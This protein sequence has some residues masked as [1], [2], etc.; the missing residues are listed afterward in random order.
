[1]TSE[2]VFFS[3]IIES[4]DSMRKAQRV[5][6]DGVNIVKDTRTESNQSNKKGKPEYAVAYYKDDAIVW[7]RGTKLYS[8]SDI[9]IDLTFAED[10]FLT[11]HCHGGFLASTRR[12]LEEIKPY[13]IGKEKIT[14]IGH[15]LGGACAAIAAMILHYEEHITNVRALT[16]AC[17]GIVTPDV[18]KLGVPIITAIARKQDPIPC[19]FDL[20]KGVYKTINLCKNDNLIPACTVPGRLLV[21]EKNTLRKTVVLRKYQEGDLVLHSIHWS[22]FVAHSRKAYMREIETVCGYN[23]DKRKAESRRIIQSRRI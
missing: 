15:S 4:L 19:I 16:L 9:K 21:L 18:A 3:D 13:L 14:F 12:A 17:P 5:L 23:P 20:K 7:F 2:L 1:M 10:N 11:G 6:P 8:F 22:K